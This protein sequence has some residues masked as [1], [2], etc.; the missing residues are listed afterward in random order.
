[1]GPVDS[2]RK[3]GIGMQEQRDKTGQLSI[4]SRTGQMCHLGTA[5][6]SASGNHVNF[7]D[8]GST[9]MSKVI[10]F[11]DR[12]VKLLQSSLCFHLFPT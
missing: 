12:Q 8:R 10:P 2:S 7:R 5:A 3:A 4:D 9:W 11:S 6:N 1:M